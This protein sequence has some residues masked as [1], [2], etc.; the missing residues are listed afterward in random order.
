[1]NSIPQNQDPRA[2]LPSVS[3]IISDPGIMELIRIHSKPLVMEAVND[4]LNE[5]RKKLKPG[6]KPVKTKEII[7]NIISRLDSIE[8]DRIRPVINATGIILHTGLGR[9]VL[10]E[11]AA[12]ALGRMNRTCNVQID[13][14][15]GLRGKRNF[16][17]EKL[18]C[19]IT[20][21]EAAAIVNNN[22]AA[23]FLILS[24][25]CKGKEVIISRGQLIEIGGSYRLPDCIRESGAIMREVGTTNKTH[26]RD[27][28]AAMNEN[29]GAILRCNP[30]NF[31]IIG[32]TADVPISDLVGLKKKQP[33]LVIDDLG[34]GALLN[35]ES[36]GLPK[37]PTIQESLASG[38]DVVCCSGDKLIGGPQAGII[39]GK[40]EL[41]QKIKKHPLM[42]MFRICKL[43]AVALEQTLRLFLDPG[44]L[45]EKNP[46]LRMI[47]IPLQEL[48]KKAQKM[49]KSIEGKGWDS[50]IQI[51]EEESATG[52]GSLPHAPLKTFVLALSLPELSPDRLCH[53]LRQ[54]DPPIIAR[55]KDDQVLLDMR[56]IMK[57]EDTEIIQALGKIAQRRNVNVK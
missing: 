50:H 51:K 54:N 27:Y 45:M 1:M 49:K 16:M 43:T 8:S 5:L 4:S 47:G 15:T 21:A 38:A 39:L 40:K 48:R 32:F 41:I 36:F 12:K 33:V 14:E 55:I 31:R 52:G 19:M 28:E 56:T 42:R 25:L 57:G 29:T 10:P 13:L 46:T 35:L 2:H 30:S 7:D 24:A 53:L 3:E 6:D 44:T 23:T 17:P 37:E 22:A 26:L 20:G 34:C 18:L 9:A 11:N